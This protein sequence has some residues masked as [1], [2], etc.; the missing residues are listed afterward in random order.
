MELT[1]KPSHI[2]RLGCLCILLV[3][4]SCGNKHAESIC[5]EYNGKSSAFISKYYLDSLQANIDSAL[6]YID[7][8]IKN[9]DEYSIQ[10]TLRKLSVF[11]L[12]KDFVSA[13]ELIERADYEFFADLPYYNELLLYRFLAMK[14]KYEENDVESNSH[15]TKCFV[16]LEDYLSHEQSEIINVRNLPSLEDIIGTPLG[17][18]ITQYYYYHSLK[19]G[20]EETEIRLGEMSI[21]GEMNAEFAEYLIDVIRVDFMEFNGL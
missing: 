8:G 4:T 5:S 18:V 9:C 7:L 12:T 13:I 19:F 1:Y 14:T 2:S 21:N 17:T 6:F 20:I 3:V 15:I 16:L 10:L 11:A